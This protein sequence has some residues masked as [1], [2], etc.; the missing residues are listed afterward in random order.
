M[1]PWRRPRTAPF[2]PKSAGAR[3]E[4]GGPRGNGAR[5][6][7]AAEA[8]EGRG[9]ADWAGRGRGRLGAGAEA[10]WEGT[11]GA[12]GPRG[13]HEKLCVRLAAGGRGDRGGLAREGAQ[14]PVQPEEAA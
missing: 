6:L 14:F 8:P 4:A 9:Q 3:Q 10:L 11:G 13:L 7:R 1:P 5:A 12:K 2:R